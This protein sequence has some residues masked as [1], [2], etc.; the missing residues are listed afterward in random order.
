MTN[1][2]TQKEIYLAIVS[3]VTRDI[4]DFHELLQQKTTPENFKEITE[5]LLKLLP[6]IRTMIRLQLVEELRLDYG[7]EVQ[8]IDLINQSLALEDRQPLPS[9]KPCDITEEVLIKL[10]E[11]KDEIH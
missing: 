4:V 1:E 6:N 7:M 2:K 5:R 3:K 10:Q 8:D 11:G 9:Y